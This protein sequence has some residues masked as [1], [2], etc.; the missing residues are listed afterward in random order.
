M[1]LMVQAQ[2]L[3]TFRERFVFL[4]SQVLVPCVIAMLFGWFYLTRQNV[5]DPVL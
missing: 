2:P 1:L 4:V 3:C 5:K